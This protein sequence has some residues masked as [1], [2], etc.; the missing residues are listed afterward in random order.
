MPDRPLFK[1]QRLAGPTAIDRFA[2]DR[3]RRWL[4]RDGGH[5]GFHAGRPGLCSTRHGAVCYG[6]GDSTVTDAA[7]VLGYIDPEGFAGG[8]FKLDVEAAR[9]ALAAL[10]AQ[11]DLGAEDTAAAVLDVINESMAQASC[12]VHL[13]ERGQEA[14]RLV[15]VASGGGGPMHGVEVARKVGARRW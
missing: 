7:A 1:G 10:G 3:G 12:A 6:L 4:Y 2:G 8:S 9:T 13:A 14:G 15:L 11:V 5:N